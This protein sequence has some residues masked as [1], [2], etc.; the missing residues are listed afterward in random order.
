MLAGGAVSWKSVKQTLTA[1]STMQAEFVACYGAASHAVWIRNFISAFGIVD[2]IA[3]PLTIYCDNSSA[4]SF[5]KNNKMTSASRHIRIKFLVVREMVENGE[6]I[7]EHIRTEEMLADPLTKGLRPIVFMKH[8]ER[9]GLV[10]SFD[11]LD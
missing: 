4:V 5:A 9:M 11:V 8:V 1:S 2:S 7:V 3:K 6:I 10:E